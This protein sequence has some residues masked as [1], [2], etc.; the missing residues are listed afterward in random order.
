[1]GCALSCSFPAGPRRLPQQPGCLKDALQLAEP[2]RARS[3]AACLLACSRYLLSHVDC[4]GTLSSGLPVSGPRSPAAIQNPS[5]LD[6]PSCNLCAD[7]S[8]N[9]R[10]ELVRCVHDGVHLRRYITQHREETREAGLSFPAT[11]P[12]RRHAPAPPRDADMQLELAMDRVAAATAAASCELHRL[13]CL[14]CAPSWSDDDRREYVAG[15][16][17]VL[18]FTGPRPFR[19]S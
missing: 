10:A 8:G 4:H 9:K 2:R 18:A 1:M 17:A 12:S 7:Q 15:S 16:H 3:I 19:E 11:A 13:W 5:W 6:F 14:W